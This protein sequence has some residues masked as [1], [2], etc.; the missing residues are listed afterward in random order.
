MRSQK[1]LFSKSAKILS[2]SKMQ[3]TFL[4]MPHKRIEFWSLLPEPR[5]KEGLFPAVN[6]AVKV[7]FLKC[8]SQKGSNRVE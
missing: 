6:L 1:A 8:Y 3:A 7:V 4:V 2:L 5:F